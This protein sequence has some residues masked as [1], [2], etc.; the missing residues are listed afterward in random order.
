MHSRKF[1]RDVYFDL[2]ENYIIKFDLGCPMSPEFDKQISDSY[3]EDVKELFKIK[4]GQKEWL[5]GYANNNWFGSG[6]ICSAI[7][8]LDANSLEDLMTE[9]PPMSK[10]LLYLNWNYDTNNYELKS[11][12]KI[13]GN[14]VKAQLENLNPDDLLEDVT[15]N[16]E[17]LIMPKRSVP[18]ELSFKETSIN[19]VSDALLRGLY[20]K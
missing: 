19:L 8:A 16:R 4:T 18:R 6:S 12:L 2:I 9:H 5:I 17:N 14:T 11:E 13:E 1:L 10:F 15:Y 7:F 3:S 20:G